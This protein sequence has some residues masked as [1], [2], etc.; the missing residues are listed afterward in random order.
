MDMRTS[1]TARR[2]PG[3]T[4]ES[5]NRTR[6]YHHSLLGMYLTKVTIEAAEVA[7][8]ED[9]IVAVAGVAVSD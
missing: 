9:D 6:L 8:V 3:G 4:D 5:D 2:M 1:G 7:V